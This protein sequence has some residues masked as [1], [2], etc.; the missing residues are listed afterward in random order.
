MHH[1]TFAG[2]E[3]IVHHVDDAVAVLYTLGLDTLA[4]EN[5]FLQ[6]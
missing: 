6:K 5:I 1:Q 2:D 3:P 4:L